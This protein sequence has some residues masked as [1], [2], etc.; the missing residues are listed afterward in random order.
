[1][2]TLMIAVAAVMYVFMIVLNTMAN[3]LPINGITTGDVSFKYP[4]LF[5][6]TGL[7]FSIW[8]LIYLLLLAYVIYQF[9][10]I[11]KPMSD[12]LRLLFFRVNLLFA[13]SSL[14]N[15][16]W[17]LAWHFDRI[18]LSTILM[19]GLLIT[20]ALIAKI[21][22]TLGPLTRT[23]FSVYFGWITIATIAN[24]TILLVKL[25]VPSF[26]R[27]SIIITSIILI[28]GLIIASAWIYLERDVA[29]GLVILWAYAGIVIRHMGSSELVRSYPLI[30]ATALGS[31]LILSIVN[32]IIFIQQLK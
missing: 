17:L 3:T 1:M 5:Q 16:L 30:Y 19:I 31:I 4:N 2:S 25:G 14:L 11:G 7:T 32:M 22:P 20:L 8:G 27:S 24:I 10:T 18:A 23:A 29:Y 28:V 15:G 26:S 12:G 13:V 9:T 21:T 6:P